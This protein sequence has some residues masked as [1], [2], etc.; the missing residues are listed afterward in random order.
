[1]GSFYSINLYFY[2]TIVSERHS[3]SKIKKT[4]FPVKSHYPKYRHVI[5]LWI[6]RFICKLPLATQNMQKQSITLQK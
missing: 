2:F 3:N 5:R 4:G 6:K 1:M